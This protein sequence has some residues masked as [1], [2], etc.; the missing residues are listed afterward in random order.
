[1]V[2][3]FQMRFGIF[4]AFVVALCIALVP[5]PALAEKTIGVI[6]TGDISY[7]KQ[8]HAAF[9]RA[10]EGQGGV[11]VVVQTP[12]PDPMSW[13]N[14]ANKLVTIGSDVIVSYGAPATLTVMKVTR[15]VPIVFAAVY[16][17]EG[18][19]ITGQNATGIG[20]TVSME[21]LLTMLKSVQAFQ[22][23]GI[24]F[25]KNEKDTILQ[26]KEL[27]SFE[28]SMGFRIKLFNAAEQGY[29]KDITGVDAVLVTTSCKGM[30]EVDDVIASARAAHVATAASLGGGEER[31]VLLTL[32]ADAEEQGSVAAELAK[33]LLSGATPASIPVRQPKK[34]DLI[35]NL[36]EARRAG[37]TIP[38]DIIGAATK[39]IE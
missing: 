28:G 21:R 1:M 20:S 17:P 11:K 34:I 6:L 24:V 7:Y 23:L 30:C 33:A 18:M 35:V 9:M 29:G 4:A 36:G 13:T 16:D 39:V 15:T 22:T 14:A 32:T 26:V 25:N 38:A 31:G 12:A 37:L 3:H 10:M 27:K 2:R 19:N 8:V 5:A